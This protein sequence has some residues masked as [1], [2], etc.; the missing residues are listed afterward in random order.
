MRATAFT[1][2]IVLLGLGA[3]TAGCGSQASDLC[4]L[5]CECEHCNDYEESLDCIV[6]TAQSDM[7]DAYGCEEKWSAW[8]TCIEEKGECEE[9]EANFSTS[10]SGSC[11]GMQPLGMSC[12]VDDDCFS[13]GAVC[14][15]T[16]MCQQRTCADGNPCETNADCPGEDR[17]QNQ[18]QELDECVSDASEHDGP[19]VDLD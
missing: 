5:I 12:M 4:E 16:G 14:D 6:V 17:C 19:F 1:K 10:G 9:E 8:A 13:F 7:A 15:A 11:S 3:A 18:A 2:A